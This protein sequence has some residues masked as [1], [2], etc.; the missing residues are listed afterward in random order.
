M[1]RAQQVRTVTN[2]AKTLY[3]AKAQATGQGRNGVASIVGGDKFELSL[4]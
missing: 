4:A 3:T 2:L 1:S